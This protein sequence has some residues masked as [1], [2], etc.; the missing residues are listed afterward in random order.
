MAVFRGRVKRINPREIK[1]AITRQRAGDHSVGES[2]AARSG[3]VINAFARMKEGTFRERFRAS[4]AWD[5]LMRRLRPVERRA[6]T[7]L[8]RARNKYV[9][10]R[11][12]RRYR[13]RGR[14]VLI[15]TGRAPILLN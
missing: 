11:A 5:Y 9:A 10:Y 14:K 12:A 15:C 8:H 3:S 4:V 1:P 2:V 6:V 13:V 7:N